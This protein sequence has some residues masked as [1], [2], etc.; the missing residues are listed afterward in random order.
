MA[1]RNRRRRWSATGTRGA[2][3]RSPART[4]GGRSAPTAW[5][6][7]RSGSSARNAP[8][9]PTGAKKAAKRVRSQG[10]RAAGAGGD[11]GADRPH[12]DRLRGPDRRSPAASTSSAATLFVK[13][14]LFGPA[15]AQGD[16]YRL[17]TS[18]FLHGSPLHLLFN[19]LMLWWFGGPLEMLL[20]R[21][22]FIGIFLV[23]I[24]A[25]SAGALVLEP[26]HVPRSVLRA[27][28]SASSA[29]GSSSSGTRSR[30]SAAARSSS[31]SST[32]SSASC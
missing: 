11:E 12:G 3:R 20:G 6:S 16:W 27:R 32:S 24:L 2:R 9:Q 7:P 1:L 28:S 13:G 22:R 4:A 26:H 23:S 30:S 15:V 31:S 14:A 17:V 21:G 5:C 8:G 29:P 18:A 25:G 19:V 10:G